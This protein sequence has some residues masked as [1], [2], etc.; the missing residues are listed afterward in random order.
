MPTRN[1]FEKAP[2]A[3]RIRQGELRPLRHYDYAGIGATIVAL[4]QEQS[5]NPMPIYRVLEPGSG[6][7]Q[8]REWRRRVLHTVALLLAALIA[9]AIGLFALDTTSQ[10]LRAKV[11]RG[12]WNALNL[13]T[14]LGDFTS[15]EHREKLFMMGTMVVF[16]MIGGYAL[17]SL[18]GFF[19]SEAMLTRREN[20]NVEHKL[21]RLANHVI[22]I[23][24]GPLGRLTAGRLQAAG[25]QVVVIDRADDLAAQASGLG[26]LVVQ[27]DAGTDDVALA[28]AS[29]A[30]AK[31]LVVTTE[32]PDR[33]LSITL[34]AHSLNPRLRIAV[35][36]ANGPRGA[37]LQRAGA[38]EVVVVDELVASALVDRLTK[39]I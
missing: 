21:E 5:A 22:L 16:L 32:E 9:C 14:T 38:S 2:P 34:M 23:G 31:A 13:V 36:G 11:F 17:S 12:L 24:F 7:V 39:A 18:T 25:E 37:L 35:T 6:V 28:R 30:L 33:K 1:W 27:G 19:S 20:R 26:Y 10:P 29:V 3:L 4:P 8:M 15:L